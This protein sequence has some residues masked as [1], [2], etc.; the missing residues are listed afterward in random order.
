MGRST[1]GGSDAGN[2]GNMQESDARS[3]EDENPLMVLCNSGVFDV[4][5]DSAAM[6]VSLDTNDY[7]QHDINSLYEVT[8]NVPDLP[9]NLADILNLASPT[10]EKLPTN[11][12]SIYI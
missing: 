8:I 6:A 2:V 9:P 4:W 7:L 11:G 5:M 1:S 10:N 3:E 12:P